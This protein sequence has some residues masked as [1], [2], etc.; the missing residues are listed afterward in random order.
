MEEEE[1]ALRAIGVSIVKGIMVICFTLFACFWV[2]SCGVS[3]DVIHECMSAC[4]GS[5]S[6]MRSV[7]ARSCDCE[8]KSSSQ[9]VIPRTR[10]SS[11]S[12]TTPLA[13]P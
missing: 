9:W 7:S 13:A 4:S 1:K 11:S 5:E 6:Q 8:K 10:T 3:K 12:T 2:H